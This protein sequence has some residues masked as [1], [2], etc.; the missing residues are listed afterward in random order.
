[1][2]SFDCRRPLLWLTCLQAL[3]GGCGEEIND[4]DCGGEGRECEPG[5]K[6]FLGELCRLSNNACGSDTCDIGEKAGQTCQDNVCFSFFIYLFI[7]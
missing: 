5:D 3:E 2:L 6:C 7:Y 1:M 4:A